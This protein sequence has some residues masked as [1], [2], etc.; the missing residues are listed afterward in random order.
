MKTTW[1]SKIK[2]ER[3]KWDDE[4]NLV[5]IKF[6]RPNSL[7]FD[8]NPNADLLSD[9][10]LLQIGFDDGYGSNN[11][12]PFI[13]Y[14]KKRIYFPV[15]YDGAEWVASVPIEYDPDFEPVHFGGG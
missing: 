8:N 7:E 13:M 2:A 14:T 6:A 15:C 11:G 9:A 12:R 10:E 3:D 5:A 4:S 1:E